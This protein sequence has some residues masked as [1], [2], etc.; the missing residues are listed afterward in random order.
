MTLLSRLTY[1]YSS[2]DLDNYAYEEHGTLRT[3]LL[4]NKSDFLTSE[5]RYVI[6]TLSL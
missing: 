4:V 6:L 2:K 3:L 1:V 5:Q